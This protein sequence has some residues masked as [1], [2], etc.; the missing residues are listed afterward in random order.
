MKFLV[1]GGAGYIGSHCARHL[2]RSGHQ[3]C[4]F[5]NLSYGSR[6]SLPEDVAFVL[7]D[8]RTS[9]DIAAVVK[10]F[11]PDFV[12]HF[13]ATALVGESMVNPSLYYDTNVLGMKNLLEALREYCN[14]ASVVFSSTCAV[15]GVPRQL[16]IAEEA[17]KNP[18][19]PYGA[20]KL[21]AE[22]M[23][24]DY[25]RAYGL[26]GMILRYFNACGADASGEFGEDHEPESHLIPNVIKAQLQGLP[27]TIHGQDFATK[28]GTCRRD[29]I[30]IED[31]AEAH[32]KAALFIQGQALGT[33]EAVHLGTGQSLS[34]LEVIREVEAFA[35]QKVKYTFGPRRAGDPDELYS[36]PRKAERLLGMTWKH[37]TLSNIIK[38]AWTW[39]SRYPKGYRNKR[40]HLA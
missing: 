33:V 11:Q 25:A 2:Q 19:S 29:Y 22:M 27:V 30:H 14:G 7:G 5:D 37:S 10:S 24:M 15:F 39:H 26:R 13:A 38:T 8:M 16:P 31:I 12:F 4:V 21:S 28:D 34:I 9:G 23:L 20:T 6:E 40:L 36:D 1:T 3:V 32:L 18:I 17:F 35:N